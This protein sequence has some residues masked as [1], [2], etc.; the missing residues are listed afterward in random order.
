MIDQYTNVIDEQAQTNLNGNITIGEDFSD[1]AGLAAAFY[2][3]KKFGK[4]GLVPGYEHYS[5]EQ[6]FFI[7]Y[8]MVG[9]NFCF[10]KKIYLFWPTL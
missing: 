6:A 5:D 2:A 3:Y 9:F 10:Q 1:L 4:P 7:G 8:A